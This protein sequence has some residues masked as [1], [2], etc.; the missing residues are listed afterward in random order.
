MGTISYPSLLTTNRLKH[1]DW[2]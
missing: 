2:Q 1:T